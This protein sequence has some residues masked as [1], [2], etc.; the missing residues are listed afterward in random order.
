MVPVDVDSV[1]V[2]VEVIVAE[3]VLGRLVAEVGPDEVG[4]GDGEGEPVSAPTSEN[5]V[6]SLGVA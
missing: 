4:A 5:E 6:V 2:P 1:M 3:P